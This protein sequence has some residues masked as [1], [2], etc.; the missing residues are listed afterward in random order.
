M[1]AKSVHQC[2]LSFDKPFFLK[3]VS[4]GLSPVA[5]RYTL[6]LVSLLIN[7]FSIDQQN[8]PSNGAF[9]IGDDKLCI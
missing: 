5:D 4:K 2:T 8:Q 6:A 9:L 1:T 7:S 3:K